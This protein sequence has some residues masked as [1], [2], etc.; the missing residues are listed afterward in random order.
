M[1]IYGPR[2]EG[3]WRPDSN[4]PATRGAH[5]PDPHIPYIY[6][7]AQPLTPIRVSAEPLL[8]PLLF[9][10]VDT[11]CWYTGPLTRC[12]ADAALLRGWDPGQEG[13][14]Q[15]PFNA[16]HLPF[17]VALKNGPSHFPSR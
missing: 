14:W 15:E 8:L 3:P 7:E 13:H 16:A 4:R 1:Y 11:W 6:I 5:N 17:E 9:F 2:V 12:C 10:F